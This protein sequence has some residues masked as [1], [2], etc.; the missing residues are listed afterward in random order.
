MMDLKPCLIFGAI[1]VLLGIAWS[2]AK[3]WWG[4]RIARKAAVRHLNAIP[5]AAKI[6]AAE[7]G[8]RMNTNDWADTLFDLHRAGFSLDESL[9]LV[10]RVRLFWGRAS[11]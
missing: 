11:A 6:L 9:A 3:A 7:P 8:S 5:A 1:F 2:L 4:A 10:K